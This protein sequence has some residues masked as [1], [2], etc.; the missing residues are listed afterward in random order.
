MLPACYKLLYNP[1]T[2]TAPLKFVIQDV[3]SGE[4]HEISPDLRSYPLSWW[5]QPQWTPDEKS[6]LIKGVNKEGIKG[7]YQIDV[8]TGKVTE[9]KAPMETSA[10]GMEMVAIF[11]QWRNPIFCYTGWSPES[12]QKVVARSVKSGEEKV[13]TEFNDWVEKILLSPDGKTLAVQYSDSLWILPADGSGE[14]RNVESFKKLKG[15]PVGWSSDNQSIYVA[16]DDANKGLQSLGNF[17][18]KRIFKRIIYI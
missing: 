2:K 17:S 14:K 10:L 12:K 3:Q 1:E 8:K 4:E 13:L 9:Y 7:L 5:T 15:N 11:A 18:C 6:I 16:N